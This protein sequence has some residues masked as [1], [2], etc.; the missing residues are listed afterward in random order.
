MKK[1]TK[2]LFGFAIAI[3]IASLNVYHSN[4]DNSKINVSALELSNLKTLQVSA[5]EWNCSKTNE[6]CCTS[7]G[8]DAYGILSYSY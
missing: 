6:T 4:A 5:G 2:F 3:V 8:E 7:P 1:H